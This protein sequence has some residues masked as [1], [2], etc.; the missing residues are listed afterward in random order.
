MRSTNCEVIIFVKI[1]SKSH[2]H[3]IFEFSRQNNFA[4]NISV[5]FDHSTSS[6][7]FSAKRQVTRRGQNAAECFRVPSGRDRFRRKTEPAKYELYFANKNLLFFSQ[8][9]VFKMNSKL[10][11]RLE[12]R[13]DQ[14]R[15]FVKNSHLRHL[16]FLPKFGQKSQ[17]WNLRRSRCCL[18]LLDFKFFDSRKIND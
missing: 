14:K 3:R 17:V 2:R 15:L 7:R 4:R 6:I 18:F 16:F 8:T 10:F 12:T 11:L 1:A 13:A 9:A 5:R